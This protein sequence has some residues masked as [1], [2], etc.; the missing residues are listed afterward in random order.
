MIGRHRKSKGSFRKLEKVR[1]DEESVLKT[2]AVQAV[3]GSIPRFS[4][5]LVECPRCGQIETMKSMNNHL[6]RHHQWT[7]EAIRQWV[8]KFR[9]SEPPAPRP[10]ENP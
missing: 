7:H 1:M 4:A 8:D 9:M 5:D 2:D 6:T 3:R 10:E